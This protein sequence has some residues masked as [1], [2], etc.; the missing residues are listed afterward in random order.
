MRT[1]FD[2]YVIILNRATHPAVLRNARFG[3][4]S[5]RGHVDD[6]GCIGWED[7]LQQCV[8]HDGGTCTHA[9]DA[10]VQ[11]TSKIYTVTPVLRGRIWDK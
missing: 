9:A 5:T 7:H 4:S 2:I 1:T 8:I 10:A 3:Q 11:C 6:L